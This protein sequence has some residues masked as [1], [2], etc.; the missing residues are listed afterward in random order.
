MNNSRPPIP[1]RPV[2]V[3]PPSRSSTIPPLYPIPIYPRMASPL[4]FTVQPTLPRSDH[5]SPRPS[6]VKV[7]EESLKV[8]QEMTPPLFV[9]LTMPQLPKE[10][11]RLMLDH[12][13]EGASSQSRNQ[14]LCSASLISKDWMELAQEVLC[15][16]VVIKT[17]ATAN[18][19]VQ[20]SRLSSPS[21]TLTSEN[22][23][24][25]TVSIS[26]FLPRFSPPVLPLPFP[27]TRDD[28]FLILAI[29]SALRM[30]SL[31]AMILRYVSS[32]FDFAR[33]VK[34]IF[35]LRQRLDTRFSRSRLTVVMDKCHIL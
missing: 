35:S 2:S 13:I 32:T 16:H 30:T 22:P 11:R 23:R 18:K 24:F 20:V 8:K 4:H 31:I 26:L 14:V 21:N 27:L 1:E 3:K 25:S 7:E 28:P 29:S 33:F 10:V 19:W 34:S 9:N 17:Q 12:A 15:Q 5:A 6:S